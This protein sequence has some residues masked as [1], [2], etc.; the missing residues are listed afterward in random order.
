MTGI[1]DSMM[2]KPQ[3][4]SPQSVSEY[5]ALQLARKLGDLDGIRRYVSLFEQHVSSEIIEAFL[6]AKDTGNQGNELVRAFD[7]YLVALTRKDE[8]DAI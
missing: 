4:F 1:L 7:A 5:E 6:A 8:D 3:G 2:A